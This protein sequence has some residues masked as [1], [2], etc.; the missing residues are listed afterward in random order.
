MILIIFGLAMLL[1]VILFFVLPPRR[2]A[3]ACLIGGWCL[4]PTADIVRPDFN[5]PVIAQ[6]DE[7]TVATTTGIGSALIGPYW[8]TRSTVIGITVLL[9][10][11]LADFKSLRRLKPKWFDIPMAIWCIAPLF[12]GLFNQLTLEQTLLNTS[13]HLIA[14]GGPYLAGRLY[15]SDI[16]PMR[17][18]GIALVASALIYAPLCMVEAVLGPFCYELLYQYHPYRFD[19]VERTLGYRPLMLLEHGNQLGIWIPAIAMLAFWMHMCRTLPRIMFVPP[20]VVVLTLVFISLLTQSLG[21]IGLMML[22]I[23][24]FA[25][26]KRGVRIPKPVW[27]AM[28][29]CM[30]GVGV[31]VAGGDKVVGKV[32]G[33]GNVT[34][35]KEVSRLRTLG[36]RINVIRR[37]MAPATEQPFIGFGQWDWWEHNE[38][39][40]RPVWNL[41]LQGLGQHGL[42]AALALLS[43][44][45]IPIWQFVDGCPFK[46]WTDVN[47][48][49]IAAMAVFLLVLLIDSMLNPA[50]PTSLICVA[51]GLNTLGPFLKRA[52]KSV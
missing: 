44:F 21:G 35:L 51:G 25:L 19:G 39:Y 49:V 30:V 36:W 10:M 9:G 33:Q 43:V 38:E 7:F 3:M 45:V 18:L 22:G 52:L 8:I 24:V 32:I 16:K 2:A 1:G 6:A 50:F 26:L 31:F 41:I 23:I 48:G 46:L 27:A 20:H 34:Q 37:G 29:V 15:F 42:I 12:S 13:Y 17:E 4:L 28:A 11:I 14:W 47:L 5:D 40:K